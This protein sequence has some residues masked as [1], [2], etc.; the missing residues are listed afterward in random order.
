M[1]QLAVAQQ[2]QA[3]M[4]V[5]LAAAASSNSAGVKQ[6]SWGDLNGNTAASSGPPT[7][8][9][10]S[11]TLANSG[12]QKTLAAPQM[13]GHIVH[14][15]SPFPTA[16][17]THTAPPG[18]VFLNVPQRLP[19]LQSQAMLNSASSQYA[20]ASQNPLPQPTAAFPPPN[21][22]PPPHGMLPPLIPAPATAAALMGLKRSWE[23]AFP[24]ELSN[25]GG[26][27]RQWQAQP[28]GAAATTAGTPAFHAQQSALTHSVA[29]QPQFYP[30]L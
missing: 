10:V 7:N 3:A 1:N 25:S 12:V 8:P 14:H 22:P 20:K 17:Q 26:V 13:Y 5:A 2:H 15:A 28:T 21:H 9:T 29:Y 16:A 19:Q 24:A 18:L 30:A 23:Q 11:V 4:A 27:K 6:N